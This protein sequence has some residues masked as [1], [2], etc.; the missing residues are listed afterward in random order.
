MTR[1]TAATPPMTETAPNSMAAALYGTIGALVALAGLPF[2]VLGLIH[3][4]RAVVKRQ[5]LGGLGLAIAFGGLVVQVGAV[6]LVLRGIAGVRDRAKVAICGTRLMGLGNALELYAHSFDDRYPVLPAPGR[7]DRFPLRFDADPRAYVAPTSQEALGEFWASAGDCNLQTV[8]LL[9]EDGFMGPDQIQCPKDSR[10]QGPD[11]RQPGWDSNSN[12]E[13]VGFDSWYNSSY[14]FQPF[15]RHPRNAAFPGRGGQDPQTVIAADRQVA[16]KAG[17]G[18]LNHST[19]GYVLRADGSVAWETGELNLHGWG[20]N[21][22]Y[23]TDVTPEGAVLNRGVTDAADLRG[24]KELPA[25]INDSVLVWGNA[26][27]DVDSEPSP[28]LAG[29]PDPPDRTDGAVLVLL[30]ALVSLP[31]TLLSGGLLVLVWITGNT[32][33]R[34]KLARELRDARTRA[35]QE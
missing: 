12:G 24:R 14:A 13:A 7:S 31:V 33:H 18:N 16:R 26:G 2:V 35:E 1:R 17:Q 32:L 28:L 3:G 21:N 20:G 34:K 30:I 9:I 29:E 4:L 10:Y 22:L 6:P 25:H 15:T 23:L 8:W 11:H 27:T 19:G 5:S